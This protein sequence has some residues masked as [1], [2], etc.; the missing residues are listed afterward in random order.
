MA[1]DQ[2]KANAGG[3]GELASLKSRVDELGGLMKQWRAA[4]GAAVKIRVVIVLVILLF[5]LGYGAVLLKTVLQVRDKSYGEEVQRVAMAKVTAMK[6]NLMPKLSSAYADLGPVYREAA[7]AD[8]RTHKDEIVDKAYAEVD[9]LKE[10]AITRFRSTFDQV[11][12]DLAQKQRSK[13]KETFPD[14]K[15]DADL[16]TIIDTLQKA[17]SGAAYDVL[18]DRTQK[19]HDRLLKATETTLQLVPEDR[20]VEFHRRTRRFMD[21]VMIDTLDLRKQLG[22][23]TQ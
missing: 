15:T 20:R 2:S 4:R 22:E 17:L 9:A 21:H 8:L 19:A 10:H 6:N 7:L 14:I 5:I 11:L 1:E 16:D 18:N 23:E 12:N 13:L 3:M